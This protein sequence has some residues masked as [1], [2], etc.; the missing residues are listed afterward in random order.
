VAINENIDP[1]LRKKEFTYRG[2]TIEELKELDIREFAKLL[3]S[4]ERRTILRQYDKLQKFVLR[5]NGKIVKTKLI[6]THNR[7]FIIIPQLVGLRI[8]VHDG[9][10]FVPVDINGEMLGHRLGEFAPTRSRVKHGAAGIGATKSS[11]A[12]A[13]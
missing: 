1:S 11:S 2:K 7:D 8:S 10:T 5:C 6:R 12:Q 9:R 4:N 3:K 13:K